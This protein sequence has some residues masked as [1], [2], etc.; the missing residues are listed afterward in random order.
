MWKRALII[1]LTTLALTAACSLIAIG[2]GATAKT[3]Q[4]QAAP[5]TATP[6][7]EGWTDV[8]MYAKLAFTQTGG[9]TATPDFSTAG[10]LY[11]LQAK[12]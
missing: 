3:A 5:K 1:L 10:L 7:Q 8:P 2:A 6:A 12:H 9:L 11:A 4:P